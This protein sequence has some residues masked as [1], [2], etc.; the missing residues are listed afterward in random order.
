MEMIEKIIRG[1][2]AMTCRATSSSWFAIV[3]LHLLK[4]PPLDFFFD[5][6]QTKQN[7]AKQ[8]KKGSRASWSTNIHHELSSSS[9][10]FLWKLG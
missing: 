2:H 1:I 4:F 5:N 3:C 9:P 10:T 6:K 7:K 8:N